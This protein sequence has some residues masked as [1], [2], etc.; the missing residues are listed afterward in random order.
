MRLFD[1]I[2]RRFFSQLYGISE[3]ELEKLADEMRARR[4]LADFGL[5]FK[6]DELQL[7]LY[8]YWS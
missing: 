1:N 8:W 4:I 2:H 3:A 6:I 7:I 5:E